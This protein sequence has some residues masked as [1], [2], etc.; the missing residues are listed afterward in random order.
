MGTSHFLRSFCSDSPQFV[1]NECP[2]S[3]NLAAVKH[4]KEINYLITAEWGSYF[5]RLS[6]FR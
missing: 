2:V 5:S 3:G 1:E 4:M 6:F